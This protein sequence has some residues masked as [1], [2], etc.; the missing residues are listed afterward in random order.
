MNSSPARL[1]IATTAVLRIG[2]SGILA[3]AWTAMR[4]FIASTLA[5]QP[6]NPLFPVKYL[7][8]GEA[9]LGIWNR[10][11]GYRYFLLA[12]SGYA[13]P[14]NVANT[15]FYPLYPM[16]LRFLWKL[17]GIDLIAISLFISTLTAFFA[18]YM[19]H[20]V[21]SDQ[22][23]KESAK[24]AVT[25][26]AVYPT[27][28]FLVGPYTE[29]LFLGLTLAAFYMARKDRWWLAALCGALAALTR[30]PGAL[31]VFPLAWIAYEKWR[32]QQ[33]SWSPRLISMAAGV[34]A[35]GVAAIGFSLWRQWMGFPPMN[36]VLQTHFG[37]RLVN[38]VSGIYN[39][40]RMVFIQ[41][42]VTVIIDA[43]TVLLWL[44]L[45]GLLITRFR[46]F[47]LEWL[48]YTGLNL[49]LVT[50]KVTTIISPLQS[51]GRYVLVLFPGF[52]FIGDWLSQ[53]SSRSR[54]VFIAASVSLSIIFCALYAVGFFIG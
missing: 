24:Y 28:L 43:V 30:G 46:R 45:F 3:A 50:S 39:A 51:I 34:A 29:G 27:A 6:V 26:L 47:P 44:G 25:A 22:F 31:T 52:I 48:I 40:I 21:V 36:E 54:F 18:F 42:S 15:V 11:D 19:L 7:P 2:I 1:A 12:Y 49:L 20:L 23:G 37:V 9:L 32:S 13:E 16:I 41:P 10:W 4:P 53:L 17:T 38:P 33:F 5:E 14:S 35:P 8:A